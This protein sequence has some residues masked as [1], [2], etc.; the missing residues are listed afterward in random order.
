MVAQTLFGVYEADALVC[1]ADA[2]VV[3]G[4]VLY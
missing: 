4:Q 1:G 3:V 2:L